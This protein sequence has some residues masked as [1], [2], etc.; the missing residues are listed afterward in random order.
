[1]LQPVHYKDIVE[2]IDKH[3]K[4]HYITV[5]KSRKR[6]HMINYNLWSDLDQEQKEEL[7]EFAKQVFHARFKGE[8]EMYCVDSTGITVPIRD[9]EL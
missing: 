4:Q 2:D 6:Q 3:L 5:F 8:W 7:I 1:M 9:Y